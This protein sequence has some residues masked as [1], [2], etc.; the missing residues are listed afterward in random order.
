MS[1]QAKK[2][3]VDIMKAIDLTT[4]FTYTV[5]SFFDYQKDLKTKSAVER[6]LS[7][8]GE[9]VNQ[10]RKHE[11]TIQIENAQQMVSF[12]NR[13]VHAYHSVDDAIVWAILKRHL[14]N[15]KKEVQLILDKE[16]QVD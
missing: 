14:P 13:L 3:L 11:E 9:A 16:E 12:R 15:L 10:F 1:E 4:Q 7:I 8:I 6:Q 5:N 2:Y